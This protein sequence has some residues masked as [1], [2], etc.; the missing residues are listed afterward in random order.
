MTK[1]EATLRQKTEAL[2]D[3]WV[4]IV[5]RFGY[6]LEI[7]FFESSDD[8][9]RGMDN[10]YMAIGDRSFEYLRGTIYVDLERLATLDSEW[11]L[12]Q[13]IVH[14]LVH[15]LLSPF[16]DIDIPSSPEE[17]VTTAIAQVLI[18]SANKKDPH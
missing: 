13:I 17:Y 18:E 6:R 3:E 2:F 10:F 15:I 9:P 8:L 4:W 7:V 1:K 12:E 5:E 14:E 16:K 11:E